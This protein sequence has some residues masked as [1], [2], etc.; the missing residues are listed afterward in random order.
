M[1]SVQLVLCV[2]AVV[3]TWATGFAADDFSSAVAPVLKAHCVS[4]HSG[5]K[6]KGELDLADITPDFAKNASTWKTVI[7]RLADGSM[8]PKEKPRPN[9]DEQK[10][11]IAW[12]SKELAAFQAKKT[13]A[14]G[15][16]RLRRLNRVEYVN[17]LRDL[18]GAEIDIETLPEDGIASGFDNVD[19]ALDLS[20]TLIERYLETADTALDAAFVWGSKPQLSK[21][22]IN[23]VPLA[24]T[25]TKT[26]K[27]MPRYG[28][29]TVIRENEVVFFSKAQAS[30]NL[31]ESKVSTTGLYR[32]RISANAVH[33][34]KG[35][36]VLVYAGNYG[37]GVQGLITRPLGAI[38]FGDKPTVV[39]FTER[40]EAGESITMHPH[41]MPNVYTKVGESYAGPGFAVQW[42]DVEGP[43]VDV[44][45][46]VATTRLLG[47]VDLAKGKL[48]DAEAII[49]RFAP[50]AFRRPV[51]DAELAPYMAVVKS[52]LDKGQSFE[53]ALRV[54]LKAILCS[55]DFLYMTAIPG[56]LND[57]DL[58]ARL[59]YC[60]WSTTPDDALVALA[61]KNELGKPDVLREQVERMLKDLKARAF[62]ENFTG[63]WLSLRNLKATIPDKKI[64]PDFDDLLEVSM[65]RET[66]LF[67]EEVLKGDRSVLEFIHSD[68]TML[69]ERLAEH[70][71]IP[72]IHGDKF[73]KVQLP[74][75]S[76]RGGVLTQAAVLKV[77]ANGT[78][79]SP[80]TR[81]AWVLDHILGTPPPPPPKDVPAIEPDIRG[82]KTIR[83][84][85]A[86]HRSIESCAGCHAKIDPVGNALE[87][88]DVIGG[89]REFYRVAPG[90]G[91]PQVR[92]TTK[93]G[94]VRGVGKGPNVQAAD[95]LPGGRKFTDVDEF[96][97]LVLDNPDQFTHG[98]TEKLLV[99]GTGHGLEFADRESVDAIVAAIK[100]KNYGFRAL[101]H[102]IVQSPTFRSK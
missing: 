71:G 74:P 90:N 61:T 100:S 13:A 21:K 32:F 73:Q 19:A 25:M 76:H 72:D 50:R 56:K 54:G 53:S 69:N 26:N 15:R 9:A 16:A 75:G 97:K 27:P 60:F 36:T 22:H 92:I 12:A 93:H 29:S 33:Q 40:L 66:H 95:E 52:R 48:T 17:T 38:D 37:R 84:Q 11:V 57:H 24:K 1:K 55:P 89:W 7:D 101:I 59:S 63:Q 94:G 87:N 45:P 44:W 39:E 102:E 31:L 47:D 79:T 43:L 62:T 51:A 23:L 49:R 91:R 4:C 80:V 2:L 81:G 41:G 20:S 99:Y 8:P 58:A 88:F 30:K 68:W 98:L 65:P 83:E 70:Y 3:A 67:F 77:T 10:V 34:E 64:Y 82:T 42:V 28:E 96:K 18:L 14:D 35:I 86:K 5:K 78:N 85:L 6:P 46:P